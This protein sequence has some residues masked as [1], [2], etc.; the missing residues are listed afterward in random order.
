MPLDEL[1][2]F[3]ARQIETG[4]GF[5]DELSADR[6]EL[7]DRYMGEPYGDEEPDSSQV[8]S[9]DVSDTVEWIMPALMDIFTSTDN[10]VRFEP[11][12]P[13][14]EE[15]ADQETAVIGHIFYNKN[16]GFLCL[17][18]AFKDALLAKNGI[19]QWRWE[20]TERVETIEE[21]SLS[22]DD[23]A[24]LI[25]DLEEKEAEVEIIEKESTE[26]GRAPDPS[27]PPEQAAMMGAIVPLYEH[28]VKIKARYTSGALK[29]EPVPPEDF[30]LTPRW[31]SV[32]V[33]DVPFCARATRTTH[34]DLIAQGYDEESVKK[35]PNAGDEASDLSNQRERRHEG[36]SGYDSANSLWA[37]DAMRPVLVYEC[38]VRVDYD[39][40]GIPE[41]VKL[42]SGGGGSS[43]ILTRDGEPDIETWEGPPPFA[44]LT[45]ILMSHKF[46]GRSI[47]E[48]V[49]DL[50]RIKTVLL[51]QFLDNVYGTQNPTT[52]VPDAAIGEHTLDDLLTQRAGGRIVRTAVG[53][54]MRETTPIP[55]GQSILAAIE[56]VDT[57]RENRSGV[58]RYN[59]GLDG[60]S[61][62]KTASGLNAI[63]TASQQKIQLIARV[64]AETGLR[65]LFRGLHQA[66]R[67]YARKEMSMKLRNEWVEIDPRQW[68]ER[69][70]LMVNVGL[71]MGSKDQ[72]IQHLMAVLQL[73]K[74]GLAAQ[75]PLV[76]NAKVFNTLEKLVEAVGLKS[77]DAFFIDPSREPEG[78]AQQ[79]Q[80]D[81]AI[82]A[83][84]QA[85]NAKLQFE[86][87]KAMADDAFKRDELKAEDDRK[88]DEFEAQM[89]IDVA[90]KQ[91]AGVQVDVDFLIALMGRNRAQAVIPPMQPQQ[92][93][94]QGIVQ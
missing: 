81:P 15:A 73:Q 82:M 62:N 79:P 49:A 46:H 50:A 9:S 55:V 42:L 4:Q 2:A 77:V 71:G 63:L 23:L 43:S 69:T 64:F 85:E 26:V 83:M 32:F 5:S 39:G 70:D 61:L 72:R 31:N 93:Q 30:I 24:T 80:G 16:D 8:V 41:R 52:E 18:T 88:R 48:M 59:Q 1:E 47:A 33:D 56:Y 89:V 44:N 76:D 58:T 6:A 11:T 13:E 94:P 28:S 74:E 87:Q 35:L 84:A 68:R 20:D 60:A 25:E 34:G 7:F 22:D 67:R 54:Q 53:G 66:T 14:D 19:I 38:F 92:L 86:I 51:R 45:P 12:G 3:V 36:E 75:S 91:A 10:A 40:D 57:M 37:G 90:E 27:M 29:V 78:G 21:S 17:H 65:A